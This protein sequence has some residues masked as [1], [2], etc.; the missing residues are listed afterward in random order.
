[1]VLILPFLKIATTSLTVG[2]GGSGGVFAPGLLIGGSFG[3]AIGMILHLLL[4]D[5]V[6]VN[7]IPIFVVIGMVATFGA[8]SRAPLAVMVMVIEMT[9]NFSVLVPAMGAVAIAF[10]LIGDETI[11]RGQVLNRSQSNAHRGEY[12]REI[13][14][15]IRVAEVMIPRDVI[16]TF[17]PLDPASLVLAKINETS[18]TGFPVLDGGQLVGMI[19]IGYFRSTQAQETLQVPVGKVM[20]RNLVTI[21]PEATL[22]DALELM[23]QH[24]IHHLPVVDP[25]NPDV[26]RWNPDPDG[27]HERVHETCRDDQGAWQGI[28]PGIPAMI[29]L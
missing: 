11:Y 14:T 2:S 23:I 9:G 13:L 7:S 25:E 6:G 12:H 24:D 27:Y 3:G 20:T 26:L 21:T 18:H 15:Q 10:L 22:E 8:V 19:T 1:M 29:L 28:E 5:L 16:I 17:S 4:P